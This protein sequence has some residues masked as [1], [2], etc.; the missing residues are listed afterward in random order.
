[1]ILAPLL[2]SI[3]RFPWLPMSRILEREAHTEILGGGRQSAT[4]K[5]PAILQVFS[6]SALK[7]TYGAHRYSRG[8]QSRREGVQGVDPRRRGAERGLGRQA[9]TLIGS[10][11]VG[12]E[13]E[14]PSSEFA[15]K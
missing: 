9:K 7:A 2:F 15:E 14:Q 13:A 12:C 5:V 10:R 1:M 8:R 4:C 3:R 6:T 11:W